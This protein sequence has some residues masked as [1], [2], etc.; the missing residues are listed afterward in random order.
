MFRRTVIFSLILSLVCASV[1]APALAVSTGA[2]IQQAK[3]TDKEITNQYTII[4]DPLENAWV[5]E[6]GNKLWTEVARKDVPYN[7]KILDTP[8]VNAFTTGGGYIYINEG[9]LDFAQSDDELAGVIGHETGHDERRH[10]VTLP[11]K[12]QALNILFGIGALLSPFVYQFGQLAEAGIIAKQ[13]RADEL[14]ADQYGLL[15]MTRAG[16]DPEAMVTFMR[17]LGVLYAEKQSIVDKYFADHP[18]VPDRINHLMG[19]PQLDPSKRTPEQT[20]AEAIHDQETTRYSV[21]AMKYQSVLKAQPDNANALLRLGQTQIALGY[22]N[23]GEQTLVQAIAAGN[24]ETQSAAKYAIT[25]LRQSQAHISLLHP[26]LQ[27]LQEGMAEAKAHEADAVASITARRDPARDQVKAVES[28]LQNVMYGMPDLSHVAV[29]KGS[30]LE[31]LTKN[32]ASISKSIDAAFTKS[33]EVIGGVGSV[34]KNKESGQLKD[35]ASVLAEMDAPLKLDPIPAQSLSVLPFYPKLFADMQLTDSDLIRA[36]DAA[37]SSLVL[38]DL[39]VGNLDL[40]VKR[41]ARSQLDPS[42][43]ISMLDYQALQP[44]LATANDNI[45]NAAIAGSQAQ[46]LFDMARSRN[47]QTR[48]TM[49]GLGYPED[50]Y[51]TLLA[52]LQHYIKNDGL[53]FSTMMR[54]RLSPGEVAS[55]SIIAADTNTTPAAVV[56]ESDTTNKSIIDVANA[57]GMHARALEIFLGLVY[58]SYTDDPIKEAQG[59]S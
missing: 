8:D 29:R 36:L 45:S 47:L 33:R 55:A 54:D 4:M 35:N 5:N 52:A 44:L 6:I 24:M 34:E 46:Q 16:Y 10:P 13:Q 51:A 15:L 49:L 40:F 2:E 14:Q 37:R 18:G 48:I 11:A 22:T 43:D 7:I 58:L 19:Y 41:L 25:Q 30:R 38:L 23:K 42:G 21:A 1:P 17:H 26:N 53:D 50:R 9:T 59:H 57:R 39:G 20:L 12:V 28:R 56:A 31:A 27:P 32:L 3:A